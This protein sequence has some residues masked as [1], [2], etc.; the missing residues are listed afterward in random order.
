MRGCGVCG[1]FCGHSADGLDVRTQ[2]RREI[3]DVIASLKVAAFID[4]HGG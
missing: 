2:D 3:S 4:A 1:Q